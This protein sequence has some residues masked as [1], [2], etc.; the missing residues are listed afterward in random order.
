MNRVDKDSCDV[1]VESKGDAT[2][3]THDDAPIIAYIC[4]HV[5]F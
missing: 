4:K 3:N 5:K 2:L 1:D